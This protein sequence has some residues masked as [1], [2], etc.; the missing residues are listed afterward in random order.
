MSRLIGR[1]KANDKEFCINQAQ[2]AQP[3]GIYK[4]ADEDKR[5]NLRQKRKKKTKTN[6]FERN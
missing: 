1:V 2:H 6:N 5:A 3:N 4:I